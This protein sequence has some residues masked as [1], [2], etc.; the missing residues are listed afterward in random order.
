MLMMIHEGSQKE[1]SYKN[2]ITQKKEGKETAGDKIVEGE[3][4]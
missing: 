2:I 3:G 1:Y 4:K